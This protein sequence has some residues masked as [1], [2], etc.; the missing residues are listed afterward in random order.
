MLPFL[1]PPPLGQPY[2]VFGGI[3]ASW[4]FSS[5]H[6]PQNSDMDYRIFKVRTLVFSMR[7]YAHG[8]WAHQQ[9]VSTTFL[10]WKNSKFSL[11]S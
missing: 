2:S 1:I 4:L 7:V 10:T 11:C 9:R 8:G 6:N 5:F 3:S